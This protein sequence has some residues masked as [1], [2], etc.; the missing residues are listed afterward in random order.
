MR[1]PVP[2]SSYAVLIGTS[3]Y[4]NLAGLPAVRHNL[5][6]L[7]A[8]L[9]DPGL[10][11]LSADHCV[12]VPDPA[13]IRTV[14]RELQRHAARA[15]D[16]LIVYFAGH[17][18]TGPRND[19]FLSLTDTDTCELPV[20]A[21]AYDLVRDVIRDSPARNRVVILDCCFSGRAAGDMAGEGAIQGQMGI[22]GTYV[23]AATSANAVAL[24]PP[25]ARHTAFTGELLELLR[26]G[27][28]EGPELLTFGTIYRHLLHTM[29]SR[30]LP[31]PRQ[32]GT[33]TADHLALT[34]NPAH[35]PA[36]L[37]PV[38]L[39]VVPVPAVRDG[40]V[41]TA[42]AEVTGNAETPTAPLE[43]PAAP[44]TTSTEVQ[45]A[46]TPVPATQDS[47]IAAPPAEATGDTETPTALGETLAAVGATGTK[48]QVP[49]AP[50]PA[51]QDDEIATAPTQATTGNTQTPTAPHEPLTAPGTTGTDV[52]VP[53]TPIP[54]TQD[55]EIA[56]A[57]AQA[58]GSAE[59]SAA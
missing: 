24:A 37:A 26:T 58:T 30:G 12:V 47:E 10:G 33:G 35:V 54:A 32:R 1:L 18:L 36:E 19:L 8:V 49:V 15:T 57:S 14:Y 42:S 20:S 23:L 34:R 50:V 41:A 55:S 59:R 9:T 29:T 43:P 40:E 7:A 56:T 39:P 6:D 53:A 31:L 13:G 28:P 17:G 51:T 3:T 25:G 4:R 21:L 38:L 16:T 44:D 11:G 5:D 22:E 48:V 27:V 2:S 45:V 46:A 52:V